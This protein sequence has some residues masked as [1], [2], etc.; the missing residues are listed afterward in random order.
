MQDA[1]GE[2]KGVFRRSLETR[3]GQKGKKR[4]GEAEGYK[5]GKKKKGSYHQAQ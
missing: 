1:R 5:K 2:K 4:G 3:A